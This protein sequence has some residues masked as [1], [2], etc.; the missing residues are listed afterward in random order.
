MQVR[1]DDFLDAGFRIDQG[2]AQSPAH[3]DHAIQRERPV[4][5]TRCGIGLIDRLPGGLVFCPKRSQQQVADFLDTFATP[6]ATG[7]N[8]LDAAP[9]FCQLSPLQFVKLAQGL[10]GARCDIRR[11]QR[12]LERQLLEI[13]GRLPARQVNADLLGLGRA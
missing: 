9:G 12:I 7:C 4:Q 5:L 10:T 1:R 2:S 6:C 13:P 11:S 8:I 3:I